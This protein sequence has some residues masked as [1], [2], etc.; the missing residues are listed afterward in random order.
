MKPANSP[1][2]APAPR[3]G[4]HSAGGPAYRAMA[5]GNEG[6]QHRA[7]LRVAPRRE[8]DDGEQKELRSL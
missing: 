7:Y 8:A 4:A 5:A 1:A 6:K 3:G 2:R